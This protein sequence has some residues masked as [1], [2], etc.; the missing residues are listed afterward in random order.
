MT[1]LEENHHRLAQALHAPTVAKAQLATIN[2][3]VSAESEKVKEEKQQKPAPLNRTTTSPPGL[4]RDAHKEL[5]SSIANTLATARG[6]PGPSRRS[7]LSPSD[8]APPQSQ[9]TTVNA[10][11]PSHVP[12]L[13]HRHSTPGSISSVKASSDQAS[14]DDGGFQSFYKRFGGF[15]EKLPASLAFTG[16]PLT[17][18]SAQE[19]AEQQEKLEKIE[20]KQKPEKQ[21]TR[22]RATDE[23]DLANIYSKAAFRVIKEEGG[24]LGIQ[25]SFYWVPPTGGTNSYANV[26]SSSGVVGEGATE[27]HHATLA[28]QGSSHVPETIGEE[29]ADNE[30]VDAREEQGASGPPSPRSSRHKSRTSTSAG[31]RPSAASAKTLEELE[32]ENGALRQLLD[33]QSRRLQMWEASSQSQGHVLAQSMRVIR[34]EK[35]ISSSA[36][37][38]HAHTDAKAVAGEVRQRELEDQLHA[39]LVDRD[40]LAHQN[41]KLARVNEQQ[42]ALIGRYRAKWEQLKAGARRKMDSRSTG[43]STVGSPGDGVE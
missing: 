29:D 7:L 10:D 5:S 41:D 22:V 32:L 9:K 23:P 21:P 27:R 36:A 28:R 35:T 4:R 43:E 19:A 18:E 31:R 26:L 42:L 14:G 12:P 1:L 11:R 34:P 37:Q 2:D 3:T 33:T 16:L 20:S 17:A 38:D 8:P 40:T 6:R 39:A 24:T 13:L 15:L 30:F 25:D